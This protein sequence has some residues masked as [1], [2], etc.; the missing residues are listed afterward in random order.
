MNKTVLSIL[1]SLGVGLFSTAS[2]ADGL[3]FATIDFGV[4]RTD[5]VNNIPDNSSDIMPTFG[6]TVGFGFSETV[7]VQFDLD[8]T[9]YDIGTF[10][11]ATAHLYYMTPDYRAK[12]GAFLSYSMLDH[13]D[14]LFE[15]DYTFGGVSAIYD[16]DDATAIQGS[17]G[18]GQADLDSTLISGDADFWSASA[19][20]EHSFTF[21]H[22]VF[23]G[24]SYTDSDDLDSSIWSLDVGYRYNFD[25]SPISL[26]ASVGITDGEFAGFSVDA[27]PRFAIGGTIYFGNQN[28]GAAGR[29]F[30]SP[31]PLDPLLSRIN[32]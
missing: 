7:G 13:T 4:S 30:N 20:I 27:E 19:S 1:T 14:N 22:G 32:F 11:S 16:F 8:A 9:N 17:I 12:V 15:L 23:A 21:N 6:A 31:Q 5:G 26:F 28:S 10:G 25:H 3:N 24:A 2:V 29:E 18:F